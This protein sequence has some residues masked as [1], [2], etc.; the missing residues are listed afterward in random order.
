MPLTEQLYFTI[1]VYVWDID[2]DFDLLE[3]TIEVENVVFGDIPQ[4]GI[5]EFK[6]EQNWNPKMGFSNG[7]SII[8][9]YQ[10]APANWQPSRLTITN[11]Q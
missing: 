6:W 10:G 11:N 5:D 2:H 3:G 9:M 8:Q 4:A 7:T 1:S